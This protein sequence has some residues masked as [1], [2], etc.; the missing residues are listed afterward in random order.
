[1][2]VIKQAAGDESIMIRSLSWRSSDELFIKFFGR[3]PD[4]ARQSELDGQK[5]AQGI[6]ND[7]ERA[8]INFRLKIRR[9]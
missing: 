9:M 4:A 2:R 1:M 8:I 6:T 3:Q 5:L 7:S